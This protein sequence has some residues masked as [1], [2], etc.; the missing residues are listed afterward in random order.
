MSY[1]VS[2]PGGTVNYYFD[3][4][5]NFLSEIIA[6]R[7]A[8]LITDNNIHSLYQSSFESY[9][10][11]V[12]PAGELHKTLETLNYITEQ[13]IGF[14]ADRQTL[15][16]GIGG[17]MVTDLTGFA[18]SVYMRGVKFGFVP[19]TLLGMVDAAIG[20]KNG[21]NFGLH[22]NMLGTITQPEFLLFD[23]NFL[24]TLPDEE[25]SNGFAEV[26]KYG[27]IFDSFLFDKLLSNDLSFFRN[28]L[29]GTKVLIQ[30][31]VEW[32][33][34]TV[35]EDEKEQANRKLLNFGHTVGHAI[36]QLHKMQHG[37]AIS[38][39][40]VV[41]CRLSEKLTGLNEEVT[42][43]LKRVLV[44]YNL[45]IE[46]SFDANQIMSVLKMDKKRSNDEIDFI[47]LEGIGKARIEKIS[48]DMIYETLIEYLHAGNH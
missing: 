42:K 19:T 37:Y 45:P 6:G 36:E 12:I 13:L 41:A 15:L 8:I 17:G 1:H 32:K 24:Q 33:N 5:F 25:W 27:C 39:G 26:I 11:I 40:M 28:N 7:K 3:R 38:I 18:A 14:E 4:N 47:V 48:F 31:C 46:I 35:L 20:G 10:T 44:R 34:K 21:V 43:A 16:I 2:F 23:Q 22:K 9:D 30:K 29:Q